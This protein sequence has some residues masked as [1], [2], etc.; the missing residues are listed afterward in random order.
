MKGKVVVE[1][2]INEQGRVVQIKV[3]QNTLGDPKVS[4]CISDIISRIRFPEATKGIVPVR[5]TFVFESG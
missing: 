2:G 3:V 1:W 4:D 5:K